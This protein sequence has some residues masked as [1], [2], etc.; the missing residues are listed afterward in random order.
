[1]ILVLDTSTNQ[2]FV[3]TCENVHRLK[4]STGL[5][6]ALE[7]YLPSQK[8]ETIRVGMG[9][10][11]YTGIRVGVVAAK[12]LAH[13]LKIPLS[14]F[15][16]L[17][18]WIP[19]EEGSF[20]VLLDAKVGGFYGIKGEKKE[21]ISYQEGPILIPAEKL[22]EYLRGVDH[23]L[24]PD[25]LPLQHKRGVSGHWV[26]A[27]LDVAHLLDLPPLPVEILYLREPYIG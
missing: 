1:M 3:G 19:K 14:G 4:G 15:T 13:A 24:S 11:S 17:Q 12:G 20:A 9:P 27:H 6:E 2:G 22:E 26:E 21:K 23:L 18:A 16:S 5:F 10:G 8:I 7:T 25:P